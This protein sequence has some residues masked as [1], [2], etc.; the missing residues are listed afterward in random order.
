MGGIRRRWKKVTGRGCS[1][2]EEVP[3]FYSPIPQLLKINI[4]VKGPSLI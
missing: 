1:M 4:K 2:S 3:D